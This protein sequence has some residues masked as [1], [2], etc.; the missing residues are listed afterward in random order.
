MLLFW[1]RTLFLL[2]MLSPGLIA[3]NS[4]RVRSTDILPYSLTQ[5]LEY[6]NY[7]TPSC[8]S[9]INE[10]GFLCRPCYIHRSAPGESLFAPVLVMPSPPSGQLCALSHPD[11]VIRTPSLCGL[12]ALGIPTQRHTWRETKT[13]YCRYKDLPH[14]PA[15]TFNY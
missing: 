4:C 14:Y 8:V 12:I 3:N 7:R 10:L 6:N 5:L 9:V 2:C 11:Y 13:Y 15:L 1:C